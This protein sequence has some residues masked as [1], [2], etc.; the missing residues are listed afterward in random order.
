MSA[1]PRHEAV[2]QSV[3]EAVLEVVGDDLALDGPLSMETS[4]NADL[5]LES[6]EFVAL[7]EVLQRRHGGVD[8]VAWLSTK[9]LDEIIALTLG[10]LVEFIVSCRS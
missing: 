5:E 2:L 6:I 4:F 1:S 3:S 8:F 9:E 7:A 10:D